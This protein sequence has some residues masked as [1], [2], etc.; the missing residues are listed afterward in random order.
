[1]PVRIFQKSLIFFLF[2]YKYLNNLAFALVL[3]VFFKF[4]KIGQWKNSLVVSNFSS[5]KFILNNIQQIV[6]IQN[7]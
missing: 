4:M 5:F 1:M 3:K 6:L 7:K 2:N